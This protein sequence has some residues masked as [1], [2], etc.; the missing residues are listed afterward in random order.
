MSGIS[1]QNQA[2]EVIVSIT[3]ELTQSDILAFIQSKESNIILMN[4]AISA[5][6]KMLHQKMANTITVIQ[7]ELQPN[8]HKMDGRLLLEIAVI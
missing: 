5:Q 2:R 1:H 6:I 3:M 7:M 8:F 4:G